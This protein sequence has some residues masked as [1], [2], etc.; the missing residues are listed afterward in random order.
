MMKIQYLQWSSIGG[1]ELKMGVPPNKINHTLL[2]QLSTTKPVFVD[3]QSW[4]SKWGKKALQLH[5]Q[6]GAVPAD[7]E[8][9]LT[10]RLINRK[11]RIYGWQDSN[12]PPVSTIGELLQSSVYSFI[13]NLSCVWPVV[14]MVIAMSRV[15]AITSQKHALPGCCVSVKSM[16]GLCHW[17]FCPVTRCKNK[18]KNRLHTAKG[19]EAYAD[20]SILC[21]WDGVKESKTKRMLMRLVHFRL[22]DMKQKQFSKGFWTVKPAQLIWP[23]PISGYRW[24]EDKTSRYQIREATTPLS[25]LVLVSLS[26][27]FFIVRNSIFIYSCFVHWV[28][29]SLVEVNEKHHI[30]PETGQSVGS[31]HGDDEG[32]H[33]VDEGIECLVHKGFPGQVGHGFQLVVDKQLRKHEE[34]AKGIYSINQTVD[35]PRVPTLIS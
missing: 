34:E 3:V 32:K 30:I 5:C 11:S 9:G 24:T 23:I 22:T 26:F 14:D 28:E 7:E 8:C 19:G 13:L 4:K 15:Q 16:R 20:V 33:I 18:Q 35:Q 2:L 17:C 27:G 25:S 12:L 21:T 10:W 6:H 29:P 31:W 1:L